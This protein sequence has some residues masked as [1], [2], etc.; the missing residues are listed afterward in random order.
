VTV[1]NEFLRPGFLEVQTGDQGNYT[2]SNL[3]PGTYQVL[4]NTPPGSPWANQVSKQIT[5]GDEPV[6]GVD[7]HLSAGGRVTGAVVGPDGQPVGGARVS[8][9]SVENQW[10]AQIPAGLSGASTTTRR[11]GTYTLEHLAPGEYT[12][13]AVAP[14][15]MEARQEHMVVRGGE[16]TEGVNWRL[17]SDE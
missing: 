11:D 8:T 2:F 7:F 3:S 10:T 13:Y 5:V 17:A 4:V 16:T 15:Y 6:A 14:G 12:L 1:F 9:A